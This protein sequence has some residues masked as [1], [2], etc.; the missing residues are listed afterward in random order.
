MK[1]L[2]E[3]IDLF[4]VDF[5]KRGAIKKRQFIFIYFE[6]CPRECPFRTASSNFCANLQ[7]VQT[8]AFSGGAHNDEGGLALLRRQ[9]A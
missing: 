6:P 3:L 7:F 5:F 9:F 8:T 1:F 4:S 2:D